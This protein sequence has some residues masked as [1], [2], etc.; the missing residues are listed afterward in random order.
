[1]DPAGETEF[2]QAVAETVSNYAESNDRSHYDMRASENTKGRSRSAGS[3]RAA[4]RI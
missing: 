2:F 1:M 4:G 3:D